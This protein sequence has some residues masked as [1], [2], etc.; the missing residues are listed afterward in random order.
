MRRSC[1]DP[2]SI[3]RRGQYDSVTAE[4]FAADASRFQGAPSGYVSGET[5]KLN[6]VGGVPLSPAFAKVAE[7]AFNMHAHDA[8][9]PI[10]PP[11]PVVGF[12]PGIPPPPP[13]TTAPEGKAPPDA[14]DDGA[15]AQGTSAHGGSA[16]ALTTDQ[17]LKLQAQR[18][19]EL[20]GNMAHYDSKF[21]A[22]KEQMDALASDARNSSEQTAQIASLMGQVTQTL[23]DQSKE[24]GKLNHNLVTMAQIATG[25]FGAQNATGAQISQLTSAVTTMVGGVQSASN[26]ANMA[27]QAETQAAQAASSETGSDTSRRS[28]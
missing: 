23:T 15:R 14:A 12:P 16:D 7:Q 24:T 1:D 13:A 27:S 19:I 20:Q 25:V 2:T 22:I 4:Q 26:A 10:P 28:G 11:A 5:A 9:A 17:A 6:A 8:E 3:S 18:L 21:S